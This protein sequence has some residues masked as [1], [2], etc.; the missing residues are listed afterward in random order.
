MPAPVIL[1]D[2]I[3]PSPAG[4]ELRIP[5]DVLDTPELRMPSRVTHDAN[6]RL[7]VG[8][9][10]ELGLDVRNVLD[11]RVRDVARYPLPDRVALAYI[12]WRTGG[13]R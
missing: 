9:G 8:A 13:A 2:W 6:L 3:T 4:L 10:L 7:D 5:S 1:D 12:G 11:K